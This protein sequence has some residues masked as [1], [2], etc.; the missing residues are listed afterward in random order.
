[1]LR[2]QWSEQ[3]HQTTHWAWLPRLTPFQSGAY[4][5]DE[6]VMVPSHSQGGRETFPAA[7]SSWLHCLLAGLVELH[8]GAHLGANGA[9]YDGDLYLDI[10]F[11]CWMLAW[12]NFGLRCRVLVEKTYIWS[13]CTKE[14]L[15][16]YHLLFCSSPGTG[17]NHLNSSPFASTPCQWL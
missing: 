8:Q 9:E 3:C 14:K 16:S 4:F 1:M 2:L 5:K 6:L 11:R 13:L 12:I 17:W 10:L 7:P 15:Q